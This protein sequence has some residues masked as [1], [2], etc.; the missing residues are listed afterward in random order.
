MP[1]SVIII[2][3]NIEVKDLQDAI[4]LFGNHDENANYLRKRYGVNINLFDG[5]V[6]IEGEEDKV[7]KYADL[8]TLLLEKSKTNTINKSFIRFN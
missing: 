3:V 6:V 7:G 1:R 5:A 4:A 8:V 2:K